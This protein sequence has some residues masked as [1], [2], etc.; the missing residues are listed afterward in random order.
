MVSAR[1]VTVRAFFCHLEKDRLSVNLPCFNQKPQPMIQREVIAGD[2]FSI[3]YK[4]QPD[5]VLADLPEGYDYVIGLRQDGSSQPTVFKLS[6]GQVRHTSTG[7]YTW[8]ISHDLSKQ[9]SGKV[10]VEMLVY[11]I[12]HAYVQHCNEPVCITVT[13]SFMNDVIADE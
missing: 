4:H 9:L 10:L 6:Q 2:T 12:D 11:S 13:P 8:T 3:V 7:V 5:G 1:I